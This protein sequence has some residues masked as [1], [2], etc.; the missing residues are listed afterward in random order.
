[1]FFHL[2]VW[3]SVFVAIGVALEGPEVIHEARNIWRIPKPEA[4][5]WVKLIGLLGWILVVAGVAGEG[6]FEGALSVAD[7]QIQTFDEILVTEAQRNAAHAIERA[8]N[9][10]ERAVKDERDLAELQKAELPRNFDP[11]KVAAKLRKFGKISAIIYSL[12]DFEP[13][14]TSALIEAALK[15]AGWNANG[16]GSSSRADSL[17][18]PGVW[19]EVVPMAEPFFGPRV[20]T[21]TDGK[22]GKTTHRWEPPWRPFV[23]A[24]DRLKELARLNTGARALAKALNAEGIVSTIRPFARHSDVIMGSPFDSI[25]IFVS[26]KPFPGMPRDLRVIANEPKAANSNPKTER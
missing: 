1:M 17:S 5:A 25:V 16:S 20:G 14:H 23:S 11:Q 2:L 22:T 6:I 18:T 21:S 8:A 7:G 9:T 10:S 13:L 26:L 15:D 19:I 12:S 4:R 24:K 3:S